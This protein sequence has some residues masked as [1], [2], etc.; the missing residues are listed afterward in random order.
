MCYLYNIVC[1]DAISIHYDIIKICKNIQL[2]YSS[3]GQMNLF[4]EKTLKK[5]F[6]IYFISSL[7]L[8]NLEI[9]ILLL[10][11]YNNSP[12]A[13]PSDKISYHLFLLSLK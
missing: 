10:I 8:I 4:R 7:E 5:L 6:G 11:S 2:T 3:I 9:I 12:F 1:M 13:S